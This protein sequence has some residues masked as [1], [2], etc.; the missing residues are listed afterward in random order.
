MPKASARRAPLESRRLHSANF[1]NQAAPN[2]TVDIAVRHAS[3]K[4]NGT[5]ST[6]ETK[7]TQHR[8]ETMMTSHIDPVTVA[9]KFSPGA[10]DLIQNSARV[11]DLT[12]IEYIRFVVL[13]ATP[14][15]DGPHSARANG[16][17]NTAAIKVVRLAESGMSTKAIAEHM[18]VSTA[19]VRTHKKAGGLPPVGPFGRSVG[20]S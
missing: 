9:L 2:P 5:V 6:A 12:E 16:R 15:N 20:A 19:F 13:A 4:S 7:T 11:K 3:L 17:V 8:K 1:T 10:W 18:N 14:G